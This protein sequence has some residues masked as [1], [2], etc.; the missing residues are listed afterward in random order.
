M[1]EFLTHFFCKVVWL[2][3]FVISILSTIGVALTI[4]FGLC[5]WVLKKIRLHRLVIEFILNREKIESEI[6][7]RS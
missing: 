6:K 2:S 3:G 7:R 4:S 5:E 1:N